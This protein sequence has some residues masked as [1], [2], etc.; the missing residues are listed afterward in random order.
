MSDNFTKTIVVFKL[1]TN[2]NYDVTVITN[3]IKLMHIY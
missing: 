1:M 2:V 3:E